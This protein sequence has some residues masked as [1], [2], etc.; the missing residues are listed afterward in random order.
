MEPM[1]PYP[2]REALISCGVLA[3]AACLLFS[4]FTVVAVVFL[5]WM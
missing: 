4:L 2:F 1:K 3:L 5:F